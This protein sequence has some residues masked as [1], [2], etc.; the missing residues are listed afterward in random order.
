[1]Y[2]TERKRKVAFDL[3]LKEN[4]FFGKLLFGLDTKAEPFMKFSLGYKPDKLIS[5][6]RPD[7][8]DLSAGKVISQ[9]GAPGGI[10][11]EASFHFS[12]Q[13]LVLKYKIAGGSIERSLFDV[14]I[15]TRGPLFMIRVGSTKTFSDSSP[16]ENALQL[17]DKFSGNK[18]FIIV[19]LPGADG[20]PWSD[21]MIPIGAPVNIVEITIP[22]TAN[23]KIYVL[24]AEDKTD[25]KDTF[26][27]WIPDVHLATK[28]SGKKS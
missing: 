8:N 17:D 11:V 14:E 10:S 21:E 18:F 13:K 9:K 22:H 5:H 3:L 20:K 16:Y 27:V 6:I 19:S 2:L 25:N 12:D 23:Q 28:V 4:L 15:P 7:R 24:T 26:G 1:M